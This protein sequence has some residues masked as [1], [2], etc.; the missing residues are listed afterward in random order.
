MA[1]KDNK[2]CTM[3]VVVTHTVTL[4]ILEYILEYKP[5]ICGG[6]VMMSGVWSR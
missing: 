5:L 4:I 3:Y 2:R 1:K 6:S